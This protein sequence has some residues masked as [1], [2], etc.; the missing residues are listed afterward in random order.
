MLKVV[1]FVVVDVMSFLFFFFFVQRLFVIKINIVRLILSSSK[2]IC[3]SR[4]ILPPYLAKKDQ[5]VATKITRSKVWAFLLSHCIIRYP[6]SFLKM[7][8]E[9][10]PQ[11]FWPWKQIFSVW[12][13]NCWDLNLHFAKLFNVEYR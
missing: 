11:I 7:N 3:S 9:K 4:M 1:F 10:A 2:M 8:S 12:S 13:D 5:L 6:F